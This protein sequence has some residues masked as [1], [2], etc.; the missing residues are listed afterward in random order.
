MD[1]LY[2]DKIQCERCGEW[3]SPDALRDHQLGHT[4]DDMNAG[5]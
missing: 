1:D 2:G 3:L 4:M 5:N